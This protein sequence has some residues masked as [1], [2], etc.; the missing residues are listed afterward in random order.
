VEPPKTA[1]LGVQLPLF[2]P[3]GTLSILHDS[4]ERYHWWKPDG[5]RLWV[6]ETIAE[7]RARQEEVDRGAEY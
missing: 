2:T 7:L 1:E 4:P 3:G 6:K 5:H